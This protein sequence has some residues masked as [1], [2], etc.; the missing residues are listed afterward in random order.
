MWGFTLKGGTGTCA[1]FVSGNLTQLAYWLLAPEALGPRGAFHWSTWSSLIRQHF[2]SV[3]ALELMSFLWA[4]DTAAAC[5]ICSCFSSPFGFFF[6]AR[7]TF[8][9]TRASLNGGKCSGVD[10]AVA[11]DFPKHRSHTWS[12]FRKWFLFC[13]GASCTSAVGGLRL[14]DGCAAAVSAVGQSRP[15]FSRASWIPGAGVWSL[16]FW[17]HFRL[18]LSLW[19]CVTARSPDLLKVR[20]EEEVKVP[21]LCCFS[22]YIKDPCAKVVNT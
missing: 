1:S 15:R 19:R 5:A 12:Y 8:F 22:C 3:I 10:S 13:G 21:N 4:S 9:L 6:C 18:C 17:Q 16:W 11:R 7:G 2:S 14:Y 20:G